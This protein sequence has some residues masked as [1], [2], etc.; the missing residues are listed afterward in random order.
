[1]IIVERKDKGNFGAVVEKGQYLGHHSRG[2][3]VRGK[4]LSK[5]IK[6]KP[7]MKLIGKQYHQENN[8]LHK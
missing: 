4:K 6:N 3:I 7:E 1:M 5:E 2:G 8:F